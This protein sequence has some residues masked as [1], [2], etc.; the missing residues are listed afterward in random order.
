MLIDEVHLLNEPGRGA[1][2][3]AGTVS[4]IKMLAGLPEMAGVG[5]LSHIHPFTPPPPQ[6]STRAAVAATA[7]LH[8]NPSASL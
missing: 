2:L 5:S 1:S 8:L 4:R 7:A 3:E 6:T